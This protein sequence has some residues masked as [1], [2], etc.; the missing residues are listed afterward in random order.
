MI[1]DKCTVADAGETARGFGGRRHTTAGVGADGAVR[2]AGEC[3]LA[4]GLMR[5]AVAMGSFEAPATR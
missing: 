2:E 4:G 5:L 1:H 3:G